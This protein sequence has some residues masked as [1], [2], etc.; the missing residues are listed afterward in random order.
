MKFAKLLCIIVALAIM[1]S[2]C[3]LDLKQLIGFEDSDKAANDSC[4]QIVEAMKKQ[5]TVALK[6]LFAP[7]VQDNIDTLEQ[8]IATLF[9]FIQGDIT[10]FSQANTLY[11]YTSNHGERTRNIRPSF[12]I[13]TSTNLYY[14]SFKECIMDTQNPHNTGISSIYVV[15]AAV[16]NSEYV[17]GGADRQWTPGVH[18]DTVA[19]PY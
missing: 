16:W 17:Y 10:S 9:N 15:D 2:A 7:A 4:A 13:E 19:C 11:D 12:S 3:T 18:I 5:D 1:L 8:D 6:S 14:M